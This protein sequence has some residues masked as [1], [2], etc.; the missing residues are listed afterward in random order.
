M[1]TCDFALLTDRRYTA[2]VAADGDWYMHNILADDGLLREALARR[3]LTSAR[4]DWADPAIDWSR[5]RCAAFRTIWDYFERFHEFSAWLDRAQRQTRLCNRGPTVRWNLDK[6]YLADLADRGIPVVPLR[7]L[8][9]GSQLP[10][11]DVLAESGWD[12]GVVKPYVSG[13]PGTRTG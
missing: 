10:L 5:F 11:A 2:T 7:F 1:P 4:V 3:G 13:R 12:E 8:E 6:H 9:R